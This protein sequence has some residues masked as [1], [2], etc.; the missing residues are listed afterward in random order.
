MQCRPPVVL[1]MKRATFGDDVWHNT[2][3]LPC[4]GERSNRDGVGCDV[5]LPA[6]TVSNY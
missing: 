1:C 2:V 3:P 5:I 4:Y 6:V